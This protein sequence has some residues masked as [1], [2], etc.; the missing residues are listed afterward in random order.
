MRNYFIICILIFLGTVSS[1]A[2]NITFAITNKVTS[3]TDV[4]FDVT[5]ASDADFKLGSG[6][7]YFNY[8]TDAFGSSIFTN[9]GLTIS[10]PSGCVLGQTVSIF[11]IYNT[12]VTNDNTTSRFSFSWQ[13]FFSS[14]A[15]PVDNITAT[16]AVL[17]RVTMAFD[18]G[19]AGEPDNICFES[20]S[21]FDDQ[22]FTAC[23]PT[24]PQGVDCGA[25]P[26]TQ[27]IND[28]FDC[29]ALLPIELLGFQARAKDNLTTLLAWQTANELNNE[30]FTIERS[31]DG[32]NF[33]PIA[34][35]AG[36][37]TSEQTLTYETIDPSPQLGINYYRLKQTDFDGQFSYSDIRSVSFNRETSA[38]V[39]VFPNPAND[40]LN[41]QF[42]QSI[43]RGYMQLFN[44][45][46]QLVSTQY[47]EQQTDQTQLQIDHLANGLYWLNIETDGQT[48]SQKIVISRD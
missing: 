29:S 5:L 39:H 25:F 7:L 23:G 17:F 36:A 18:T 27:L 43:H 34:H 6:Q 42:D 2:Q 41:I 1:L 13:Q 37:G 28:N 38:G 11:N 32:R 35:H 22:T 15:I 24:A 12:F 10:Y 19:G 45:S 21:A 44:G 8:N 26:G 40:I 30:L 4:T 16:P 48:Y 33:E 3:S 20:G 47:L 31:F 46:G 14:G 9:G